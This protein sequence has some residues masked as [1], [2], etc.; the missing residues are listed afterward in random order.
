MSVRDLMDRNMELNFQSMKSKISRAR[1]WMG[2]GGFWL[3]EPL[4]N[5][6]RRLATVASDETISPRDRIEA[7]K[8]GCEVAVAIVKLQFYTLP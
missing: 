5:A 3:K 7:E 6:Y 8:P 1:K 4:T 2:F